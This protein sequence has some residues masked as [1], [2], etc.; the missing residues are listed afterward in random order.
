MEGELKKNAFTKTCWDF[1]F[2]FLQMLD[3]FSKHVKGMVRIYIL[4]YLSV[5]NK[6]K[7][8]DMFKV[9]GPKYFY[10]SQHY[11]CILLNKALL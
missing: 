5:E 4:L 7:T 11:Y 1:Q 9:N 10:H 2:Y 8:E 6:M 3:L